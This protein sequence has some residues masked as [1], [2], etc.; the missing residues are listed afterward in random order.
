MYSE[1]RKYLRHTV[2]VALTFSLSLFRE[3]SADMTESHFGLTELYRD[4]LSVGEINSGSTCCKVFTFKFK[5]VS[6]LDCSC[7]VFNRN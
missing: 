6:S 7:C 3:H 4:M 1:L 2:S 5:H